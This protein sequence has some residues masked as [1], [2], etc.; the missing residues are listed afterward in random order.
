VA[1]LGQV[2][3]AELTELLKGVDVTNGFANRFLWVLSHRAGLHPEPGRLPDDEIQKFGDRLRGAIEFAHA[4]GEVT[5]SP[6]FAIAWDRLYRVVESQPSGGM[7]YDSLTAR[8]SA[9]QLRLALVYALLDRSTSLEEVHLRAAAALWDYAE[10]SVAYIWGATLGNAR[11]DKLYEAVAEAGRTG[12]DRTQVN[13]LF[14][15][16]LRKD[17]IDAL[18]A[19]LLDMGLGV[20]ESRKTGGRPS[21]VLVAAR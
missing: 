4:A 20:L 16:N 13:G 2:T 5:R 17:E 6:A 18:V 12:L 21:Q 19:Q 7:V 1:V 9:Y 11:L 15:N 3:I 10:A 14:S 8:A